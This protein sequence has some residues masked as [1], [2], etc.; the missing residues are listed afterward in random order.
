LFTKADFIYDAQQDSYRCPAGAVLTYRF[1]TVEDGRPQR[2]SATGACGSCTLRAQCTRNKKGRRITRWE[3]EGILDA[4]AERVRARPEIMKQRKQIV[5]HPFGTIKRT[6]NQSYFLL[7]GLAKVRAEISLTVL[8][9]NL[10]RVITILGVTRLL[11][12]VLSGVSTCV[13]LFIQLHIGVLAASWRC[14]S[15]IVC[16]IFTQSGAGLGRLKYTGSVPPCA[17]QEPP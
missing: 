7:R 5:E 8:A 15:R 6:M 3:D 4:M 12:L 17:N 10:K 2:Y 14:A 11:E 16:G 13:R 1:S 9:Y